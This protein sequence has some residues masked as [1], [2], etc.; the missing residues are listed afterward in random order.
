MQP[1]GGT[2]KRM[3]ERGVGPMAAADEGA[4]CLPA[5]HPQP[6]EGERRPEWVVGG[7]DQAGRGHGGC[8]CVGQR[9]M[10]CDV[11]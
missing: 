10:D 1:P 2:N 7:R 3:N 4:S 6:G 5:G 8:V 9:G 11:S